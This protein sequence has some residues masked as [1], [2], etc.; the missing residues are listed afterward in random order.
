VTAIIRLMPLGA[1]ALRWATGLS[2]AFF[3]RAI[4]EAAQEQVGMKHQDGSRNQRSRKVP[5]CRFRCR[6]MRKEVR[7][8]PVICDD[9]SAR[10]KAAVFSWD[11]M[12]RDKLNVFAKLSQNTHQSVAKHFEIEAMLAKSIAAGIEEKKARGKGASCKSLTQ[13]QF[14]R[15]AVITIFQ[16]G[17]VKKLGQCTFVGPR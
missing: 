7:A 17:F 14:V 9:C 11:T 5:D 10:V 12:R 16:L 2:Q 3:L 1:K 8:M 15:N 13:R 4:D 6:A